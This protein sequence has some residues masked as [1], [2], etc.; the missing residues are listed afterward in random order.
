[1][2]NLYVTLFSAFLLGSTICTGCAEKKPVLQGEVIEMIHK[3][4][5]YWQ[6]NHP[7][8]GRSFWDNAAYH[9]GNMEVYFLTKKPEYLEYSKEWAEHNQWKG[10]KSDDKTCWKYSYGESD[11]YVLFGDYQICFQTYADL[12]NLEPD[13]QKIARAAEVMEYQMSTPN[14]DYWWWADGLYIVMPVMTK[15]YNITQNPLYLE[16]LH[17]YLVYADSIMY[18]E[19]AGLYY[20]DGKYVYPKHKSVNGKKD[21]WARGDGWVLAGLAKVLKDLPKTD[22][23]RQ[24]YIDRFR[25]L[26]KSVAACQQP[27]GYWTRSMLDP[28]HAPGPETSGTAFFAYGLQ[29]GINNGFLNAGEYQPIVEKAWQYLITVALQPDG[30]IGYVQ[31]IGEKAIP[32][33]VVDANSTSNFGVGAF[34]LAACERVRYLN[35]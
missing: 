11:D 18:D 17:E 27:E 25:T 13:T 29:W 16:K 21:F 35:K 7:E 4:N 26:A 22:K 15:M 10:A 3:V 20:R 32:G 28:Q 6:M 31:P 33:Q 1:M 9:T 14:R 5:G 30:K 12:Y 34:L 2:K 8:H 24:E 19:E 23:Y